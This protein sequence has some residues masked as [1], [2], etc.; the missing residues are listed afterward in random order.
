MLGGLAARLDS[1]SH[2]AVLARGYALVL[3][4]AGHAVTRAAEVS[5][6]SRLRLRF[7]DGE[8]KATAEGKAKAAGQATLPF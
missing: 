2:E 6:A 7:A 3:T 4:T 1:V 8:I 5:P